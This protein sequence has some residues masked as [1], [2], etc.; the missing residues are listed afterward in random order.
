MVLPGMLGIGFQTSVFCEVNIFLLTSLISLSVIF[1]FPER[2]QSSDL[3]FST[4][5]IYSDICF[6]GII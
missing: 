3:G 2:I 6:K 5:L 1:F 4:I